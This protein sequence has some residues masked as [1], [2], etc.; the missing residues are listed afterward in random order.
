MTFTEYVDGQVLVALH[1]TPL[2]D[3]LVTDVRAHRKRVLDAVAAAAGVSDRTVAT[4][5]R[6]ARTSRY[7]VA[8]R[9][10]AATG[11][12]VRKEDLHRVA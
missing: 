6:G 4:L 10:S 7:G 5:Y 8:E 3:A 1:P 12:K 9:V 2:R 11:G